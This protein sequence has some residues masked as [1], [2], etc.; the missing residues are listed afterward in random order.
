MCD[1]ET[2]LVAWLDRELTPDEA[3]TVERHVK[4]CQECRRS[5]AAYERM[6]QTFDAY[7]DAVM[8]AK[9]PRQTSWVPVL[10]GAF[11]VAAAVCL[12]LLRTRVVPPPV[13]EPTVAIASAPVPGPLH[14]DQPI[15]RKAIIRRRQ[16]APRRL[17]LASHEEPLDA[18]IQIAIPAEAMF[19]PGAVPNGI[20][21]IAELTIAQDGSVKQVLLR[22]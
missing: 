13:I 16:P 18:A 21:L 1:V 11:V 20:N 19:P 3:S 2:K 5:V 22:Q 10:A 4:R 15:V 6:S 7:C 9:A 12:A 8:A 17:E 14:V